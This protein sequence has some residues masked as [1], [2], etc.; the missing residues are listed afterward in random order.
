[1][2]EI[3]D[4]IHKKYP[5]AYYSIALDDSRILFFD[6]NGLPIMEVQVASNG[7]NIYLSVFEY[8][9]KLYYSN[10]GEETNE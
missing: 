5:Q 4:E 3:Y 1:M 9:N 2:Q 7:Y 10:N 8:K 6:E